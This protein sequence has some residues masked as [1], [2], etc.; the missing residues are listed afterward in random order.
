[1]EIYNLT[2]FVEQRL[3]EL[4]TYLNF[5]Q[6]FWILNLVIDNLSLNFSLTDPIN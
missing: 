4:P 5:F 3:F 2:N 6:L 1:M